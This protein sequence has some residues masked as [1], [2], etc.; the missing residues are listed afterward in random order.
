MTA[1]LLAAGLRR[2]I[3]EIGLN[4]PN[5]A[6]LNPRKNEAF[7]KRH[8]LSFVD[9]HLQ[10]VVWH[11]LR[12]LFPPVAHIDGERRAVGFDGSMRLY[13]YHRGDQ[14]GQHVDVSTR[15]G[16]GEETEYTVRPLPGAWSRT[17]DKNRRS[18]D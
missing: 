8:S 5:G 6:D 18:S 7:L 17:H 14:F 2:A 12:R 15:G 16:P 10:Q 9:P 4:P 13:K 3:D 1:P 11:R